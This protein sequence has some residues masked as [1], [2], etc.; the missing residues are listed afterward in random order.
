[1]PHPAPCVIE[2]HYHVVRILHKDAKKTKHVWAV[3]PGSA[4][5][6]QRIEGAV[7]IE[8]DLPPENDKHIALGR[9]MDT[10]SKL[11][12]SLRQ[13]LQG[14]LL[15]GEPVVADAVSYSVSGTALM[16][17]VVS[18][19]SIFL[20][21][22]DRAE[23][24]NLSERFGKLNTKRNYL[25]HGFWTLE[26]IVFLSDS[27]PVV[28]ASEVREYPPT[29]MATREALS[30]LKNQSARGRYLFPL[31]KIEQIEKDAAT[32]YRDFDR[33]HA[34]KLVRRPIAVVPISQ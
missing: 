32:L 2:P 10:W 30:D 4:P 13:K 29:D 34:A 31:K 16:N 19:A 23:Y 18:L 5:P 6:A 17:M 14:L 9:F 3:I 15:S 22:S 8:P 24:V 25:V 12:L 26:L 27:E 20:K 11:E 7:Y 21:P 1:M 33:F 28:Q